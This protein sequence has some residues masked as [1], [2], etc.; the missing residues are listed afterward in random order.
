MLSPFVSLSTIAAAF[1]RGLTDINKFKDFHNKHLA[2]PWKLTVVSKSE[3]Q[4]LAARVSNLPS[5]TVP[6]EAILLTCGIDVQ[7]YGYWFI[8]RAWAS[9]ITS[10]LIHYGFLSTEEELDN[11]IF[12]TSYPVASS[13]PPLEEAGGGTRSMRIFRVAKDTG[14]GEKYED[15]T[16]TDQTYLWIIR[17][18]GRNGVA[19]WGTKGSSRALP[20]MLNLGPEI[21]STNSG[22]KLPGGLRILSVDTEKAKD[23]FHY[24]LGLAVNPETRNLPGAAFLHADVKSDYITQILAE[25]KQLNDKGHEEWVNVHHRPNHLLDAEIL[26][27]ACVEMEFPGGGLRL[28]AGRLGKRMEASAEKPKPVASNWI[29]RPAAGPGGGW[30]IK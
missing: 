27:A 22:K 29:K 15:M 19:V 23:Q 26:A 5:Q 9:Q 3:E 20:G 6:E 10:W 21:L 4:I 13:S 1:L 25:E 30:K 28:I 7:K 14:G 18:R 16:M 2:E 17:N 8:V 24:R 12:N 11:L